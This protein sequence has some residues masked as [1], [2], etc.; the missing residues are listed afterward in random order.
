[1]R[2]I[3]VYGANWCGDTQITRYQLD[4]LGIPYDYFDVDADPQAR[5]WVLRQNNGKQKTPTVDVDGEIL[6]EPDE[7][8]L[9]RVLHAKGLL[10]AA[11]Y[12]ATA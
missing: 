4:Q 3:K 11:P 9:L 7:D 12:S 10:D 6:V 2:A 8:Q 5:Q 1:M